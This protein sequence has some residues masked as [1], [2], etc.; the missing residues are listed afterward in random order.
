MAFR[1]NIAGIKRLVELM[2]QVFQRAVDNMH[3][4][5]VFAEA[6]SGG[7]EESGGSGG[8]TDPNKAGVIGGAPE[9]G[10]VDGALNTMLG[11]E[12]GHAAEFRAEQAMT[13]H[14]K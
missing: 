12:R 8:W 9:F 3:V 2:P 5:P 14:I 13:Y 1:D 11:N 7:D 4:L 10:N 6:A